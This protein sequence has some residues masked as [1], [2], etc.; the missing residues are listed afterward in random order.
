M[1]YRYR[2]GENVE[3]GTQRI[4]LEQLER[5]I[6][7]LDDPQ[8]ASAEAVHQA[9]KRLKKLRGLLRLVRPAIGRPAYRRYNKRFRDLGRALSGAR[10]TEVMLQTLAKLREVMTVGGEDADLSGLRRDL[11]ARQER[12]VISSRGPDL[13]TRKA[14]VRL[15][16]ED[17]CHGI[18][19]WELAAKEFE[20]VG[21]GLEEYHRRGCKALVKARRKPDDTRF[22]EWRKRVKDHWYHVRLLRNTW[23][24]LMKTYAG[25]MKRLSDLLGDDHDLAV[26]RLTLDEVTDD[27]LSAASRNALLDCIAQRQQ[28]LRDEAVRLGRRVYADKPKSIRQRIGVGWRVWR[29]T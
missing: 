13:K 8:L 18:E 2:H 26:F 27:T 14:A 6:H 19:N 28:N 5:A 12:V 21:P 9:R 22:H 1:T 25:E 11:E 4:A 10:D 23:P 17:A 20:A 16:L 29:K 3:R 7:E 24:A 15:E